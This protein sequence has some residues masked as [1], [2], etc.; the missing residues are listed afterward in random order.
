LVY[1]GRFLKDGIADAGLYIG[2]HHVVPAT[3]VAQPLVFFS[4]RAI[5]TTATTPKSAMISTRLNSQRARVLS[6]TGLAP[7]EA[8]YL[9]AF[10]F[11][12]HRLPVHKRF[13]HQAVKQDGQVGAKDDVRDFS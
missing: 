12:A 7:V 3:L 10:G 1:I 4:D 13:E 6:K 9:D 11:F 8:Y 5:I 2:A